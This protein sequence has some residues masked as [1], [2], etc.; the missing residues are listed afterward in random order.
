MFYFYIFLTQAIS[1]SI[2][3]NPEHETPEC[4]YKT[5]DDRSI[6]YT[7]DLCIQSRNET[8][9]VGLKPNGWV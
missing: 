3:A 4:I 6:G 9:V 8:M 7:L 2:V 1:G 5:P